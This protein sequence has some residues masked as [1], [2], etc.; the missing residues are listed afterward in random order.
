MSATS[1]A[2]L[3]RY[4]RK[5]DRQLCLEEKEEKEQASKR[6]SCPEAETKLA[7]ALFFSW[8]TNCPTQH[9]CE[10]NHERAGGFIKG[11][12]MGRACWKEKKRIT[13]KKARWMHF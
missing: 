1:V 10:M 8:H 4:E 9:L 2:C 13:Q 7:L 3:R 5:R 6:K 12:G 11:Q